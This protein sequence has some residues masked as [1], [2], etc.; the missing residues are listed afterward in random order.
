MTVG[1]DANRQRLAVEGNAELDVQLATEARQ[2]DVGE[3]AGAEY[4]PGRRLL[5][6]YSFVG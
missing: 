3:L 5:G 4:R 1:V 2:V 6:V